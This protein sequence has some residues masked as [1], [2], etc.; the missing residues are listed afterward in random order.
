[1]RFSSKLSLSIVFLVVLMTFASLT[2]FGASIEEAHGK[3]WRDWWPFNGR[4]DDNNNRGNN[5]NQN[6]PGRDP[7]IDVDDGGINAN[8]LPPDGCGFVADAPPDR[9]LC[10]F[11][12]GS[13]PEGGV[14]WLSFNSR[15]CDSD[16]DGDAG[17]N[18]PPGCPAAETPL[19]RYGVYAQNPVDGNDVALNPNGSG[20]YPVPSSGSYSKLVGCAWSPNIGWVKFGGFASSTQHYTN[21]GNSNINY[22]KIQGI[23]VNERYGA[24]CTSSLLLGPPAPRWP[25]N[26]GN[27]GNARI[28]H[29]S[30]TSPSPSCTVAS[31][32]TDLTSGRLRGW[33]R[34][35]AGTEGGQCSDVNENA[36]STA[37]GGWDGWVALDGYAQNTDPGFPLD[38]STNQGG[39][40]ASNARVSGSVFNGYSWGGDIL[41]WMKWGPTG[42]S[43]N[44]ANGV[45][46]CNITPFDFNI[47]TSNQTSNPVS[48]SH[49]AGDFPGSTESNIVTTTKPATITVTK[50]GGQDQAVSLVYLPV[51]STSTTRTIP[52][53]S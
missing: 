31:P 6:R 51:P 1:M 21:G 19:K 46:F 3:G 44:W 33:A 30:L 45:H 12:W 2:N 37:S 47:A 5:D 49:P 20:F 15:D 38:S 7:R 42:S 39:F 35:C 40:S 8:L 32:C 17:P 23:F 26:G 36:S 28:V 16:G 41:G 18:A 52:Q 43:D 9:Q 34:A 27:C 22:A 48:F 53:P 11:A 13:T 29:Y 25:V 14:G 50:I 10:G 24:A 4:N